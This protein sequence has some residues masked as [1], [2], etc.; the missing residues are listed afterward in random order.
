MHPLDVPGRKLLAAERFELLGAAAQPSDNFAG[1]LRRRLG[2][3]VIAAGRRLAP[4]EVDP[5]GALTRSRQGA[6]LQ[7]SCQAR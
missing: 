5:S 7:G 2:K 3:V 1:Q 6:R 4:E